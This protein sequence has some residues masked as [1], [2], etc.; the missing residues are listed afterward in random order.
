M[1]I[2]ERPISYPELSKADELF[3]TGNYTKVNPVLQL[4]DRELQP[5]PVAARARELYFDYAERTG[6]KRL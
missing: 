2:E 3:A 1:S 4:D 5:G 6:G